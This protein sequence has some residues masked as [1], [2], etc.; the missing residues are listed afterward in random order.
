MPNYKLSVIYEILFKGE[1]VYIGST[2][3]LTRRKWEHKSSF[4]KPKVHNHNAPVYKYIREHG[5]WE[6]VEIKKIDDFPC[7][8]KKELNTKEGEYIKQYIHGGNNIQ[9]KQIAGRDAKQYAKDN[10]EKIKKYQRSHYNNNKEYYLNKANEYKNNNIEKIKE[11]QSNYGKNN[12]DKKNEANR[13]YKAK[14]KEKAKLYASTKVKCSE[15][16]K[17]MRRDSLNKHKKR[18]HLNN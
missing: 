6:D 4:I 18:F 2:T 15:C 5:S 10:K 3:N 8:T 17:E 14:N 7:E 13:R 1:P 16:D 12:R 9:N 11:Y